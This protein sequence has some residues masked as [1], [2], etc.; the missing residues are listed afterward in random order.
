MH[1]LTYELVWDEEMLVETIMPLF[2]EWAFVLAV[3]NN[4]ERKTSVYLSIS[5]DMFC[6][7]MPLKEIILLTEPP[8]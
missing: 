6:W 8:A 1:A 5:V 4:A 7:E 3:R 2:C